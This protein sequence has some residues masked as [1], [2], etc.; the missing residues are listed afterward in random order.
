MRQFLLMAV[1]CATAAAAG[2][3]PVP[4]MK[5]KR[6]DAEAFVG[7]WEAMVPGPGGQPWEKATW[8]IDEKLALRIESPE[9][10][11]RFTPWPLTLSPE[12]TPKGIDLGKFKGIYELDGDEIRVAYRVSGDRP[13]TVDPAPGVH[14]YTLRRVEPKKVK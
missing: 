1:G 11:G 6:P 12:Q 5:A 9:V 13:S 3:A 8:V 14:T 4:K 10:G 2:A 7:T